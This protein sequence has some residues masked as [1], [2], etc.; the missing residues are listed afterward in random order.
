MLKNIGWNLRN[1]RQE[2]NL[3]QREVA[4]YVGVTEA[5]VS[6]WESGQI[7]N[8]RRDRIDKLARILNVS[9]LAVMG[10]KDFEDKS[11]AKTEPLEDS[12]LVKVPLV[13]SIACGTP[14]LAE[15]N[16][17]G[18]EYVPKKYHAD[19]ALQA[20]G[21]SMIG[22]RIHDGDIVFV[23]QVSDVDDGD[24]A[25]VLVDGEA[26]LKRIY[27]SNG[28]LVLSPAN[29]AYTPMVLHGKDQKDVRILGK[30]VAF[31]SCL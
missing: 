24:I 29:P 2:R 8:M 17:E 18:W 26:T 11:R 3:S 19:F 22:D 27:K 4:N 5:T 7:G 31:Q 9:P 15:E 14:V 12:Y 25:A 10:L 6:R 23:R 28:T 20:K 13:G 30:A 16:T 1:R 21:D